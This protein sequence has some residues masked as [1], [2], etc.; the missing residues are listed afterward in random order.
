MKLP[1]ALQQHVWHRQAGI[2]REQVQSEPFRT[3][4]SEGSNPQQQSYVFMVDV[5]ICSI[6]SA[7]EPQV[8]SCLCVTHTNLGQYLMLMDMHQ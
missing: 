1:R 3:M 2:A 6:A 7:L 5:F 4:Q 8:L